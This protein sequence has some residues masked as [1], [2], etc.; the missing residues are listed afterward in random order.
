MDYGGIREKRVKKKPY[1]VHLQMAPK[2]LEEQGL[3]QEFSNHCQKKFRLWRF[4]DVSG[5]P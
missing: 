5:S 4:L 2:P 3:P 1:Y